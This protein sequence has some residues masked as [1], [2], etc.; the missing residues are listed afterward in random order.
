MQSQVGGQFSEP[1]W[2]LSE[3]QEACRGRKEGKRRK[4]AHDRVIRI[5]AT[6]AA[7]TD[8]HSGCEMLPR[9]RANPDQ[10]PRQIHVRYLCGSIGTARYPLSGSVARTTCS[11]AS[12][13]AG[14]QRGPDRNK[15]SPAVTSPL[16]R[17]NHPSFYLPRPSCLWL[18]PV[19]DPHVPCSMFV[20]P[21]PYPEARCR[22]YWFGT[23]LVWL[24]HALADQSIYE[25]MNRYSQHYKH[26]YLGWMPRYGRLMSIFGQAINIIPPNLFRP[27]ARPRLPV[28]AV[29]VRAVLFL[30]CPGSRPGARASQSRR[31]AL[32]DKTLYPIRFY[33][34]QRDLSQRPSF[35]DDSRASR[36]GMP[37]W[38]ILVHTSP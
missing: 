20:P 28:E 7:G 18:L 13:R 12:C 11:S 30:T 8:V 4:K 5:P 6:G 10:V 22:E 16:S 38:S 2:P 27:P 15:Q 17:R 9:G 3:H 25:Y 24:I 19:Y 32:G 23:P 31:L 34:A 29:L 14:Y 26:V 21:S 33:I 37:Y 35:Q 36:T 1:C